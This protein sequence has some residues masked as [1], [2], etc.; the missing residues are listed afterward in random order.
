M[1]IGITILA[2]TLS[3]GGVL[4]GRVRIARA[5]ARVRR[6]L[7]VASTGIDT[8]SRESVG[9]VV[10]IVGRVRLPSPG[11]APLSGRACALWEVALRPGRGPRP[12]P[13]LALRGG[14]D[15][16]IVDGDGRSV[17]VC[18]DARAELLLRSELGFR[19]ARRSIRGDARA[20]AVTATVG[21][22]EVVAGRPGASGEGIPA[23]F[24]GIALP[25]LA[26]FQ[27]R[28]AATFG[29]EELIMPP[30]RGALIGEERVVVE[31][32]RVALVGTV[33]LAEGAA[34]GGGEGRFRLVGTDACRLAI[35]N[36][37]GPTTAAPAPST[38]SDAFVT[39]GDDDASV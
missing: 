20:G 1:P 18:W 17:A 32:Q 6:R 25:D 16:E 4:V 27:R 22:F 7:E 38:A 13:A 37:D 21:W 29:A 36:I 11:D 14:G 24:A 23:C 12:K 31:G 34:W 19:Y 30:K 33:A 28:F 39:H 35:A 26:G 10:K 9:E 15:F 8:L 5:R 3:Y 2:A